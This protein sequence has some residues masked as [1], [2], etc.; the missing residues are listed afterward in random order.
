MHLED[1]VMI[2]APDDVLGFDLHLADE[3]AD[4]RR[5]GYLGFDEFVEF[6]ALFRLEFGRRETGRTSLFQE[7]F[8][9]VVLG[10]LPHEGEPLA[11]GLRYWFEYGHKV[12]PIWREERISS[13]RHHLR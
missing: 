9:L 1:G 10:L 8:V 13:S 4:R 11:F 12:S 2:G 5:G 6:G 3:D 7:E